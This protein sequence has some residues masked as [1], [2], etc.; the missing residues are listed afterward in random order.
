MKY[1]ITI[2]IIN[3][4]GLNSQTSQSRF[5]KRKRQYYVFKIRNKQYKKAKKVEKSDWIPGRYENIDNLAI[6]TRDKISFNAKTS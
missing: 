2:I 4:N 3:E 5:F 1:I 6:S